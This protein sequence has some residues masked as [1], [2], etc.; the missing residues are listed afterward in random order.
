MWRIESHRQEEPHANQWRRPITVIAWDGKTLAADKRATC[1]GLI[2][3]ATKIRRIGPLLVA[4]SGDFDMVVAAFVW[5]E[6]GRKPEE[7]TAAMRDK[8]TSADILVIEEGRVLKYERTP[9]PMVFEDE[10]FAMGSG[11]DYAMAAMYMGG[12]ARTAVL[13]ASALESSC[14]NGVD[15]LKIEGGP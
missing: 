3:T 4:G 10:H 15:T 8:D 11:R 14:G 9:Y 1:A 6:G 12:D 5:V 2:R 13:V 7:F